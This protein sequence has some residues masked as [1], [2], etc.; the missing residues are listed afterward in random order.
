MQ[1]LTRI[2][3]IQYV[4]IPTGHWRQLSA[5]LLLAHALVTALVSR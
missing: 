5:P 4:D 1:E 3:D 2:H